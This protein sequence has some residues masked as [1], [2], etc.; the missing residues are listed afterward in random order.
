MTLLRISGGRL[1]NSLLSAFEINLSNIIAC[2]FD[3]MLSHFD[4]FQIEGFCK[5]LDL[6]LTLF[7]SSTYRISEFFSL[8]TEFVSE[9]K[10]SGLTSWSVP[11][12]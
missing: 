4:L 2:S 5:I 7:V 9:S 6:S 3:K 11:K 12:R 1:L 8:E 10:K